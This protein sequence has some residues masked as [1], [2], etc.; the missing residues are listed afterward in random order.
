MKKTKQTRPATRPKMEF[1]KGNKKLPAS[2]YI[3]NT[4]SATD[5]PSRALGLCQCPEKCY[6]IK[7]E[8]QYPA[9]L[10]YRRRQRAAFSALSAAEI[11]E[12]LLTASARSRAGGM[13]RFRFSEAGDFE[14]QRDV[15]KM[16]DLCEILTAAGV[17]CYGYTAHTDLELSRLCAAASLNVSNDRGQW[18]AQGANRFKAVEKLDRRRLICAGDCRKCALCFNKRGATIQVM[19]H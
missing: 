7:A 8:K 16:A 1:S 12:Q 15:D 17:K 18:T 5:C 9:V 11:A 13:Q 10:P 2:T 19:M 4:G 14:T 6:A 3:L